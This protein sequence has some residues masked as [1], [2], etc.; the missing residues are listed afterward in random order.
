[1]YGLVAHIHEVIKYR[2]KNRCKADDMLQLMIDAASEDTR[3]IEDQDVAA[4]A[5]FFLLAGYETT[6]ITIAN[7]CCLMA[8]H[9]EE[10]EKLFEEINEVCSGPEDVTYEQVQKLKRMEAFLLETLRMFPPV[11]SLVSRVGNA[12]VQV[13]GFHIPKGTQVQASVLEVHM[14][15]KYWPDPERFNPDRFVDTNAATQPQYLPFGIGPKMCIGRRFSLIELKITFVTILR[16]FRLVRSPQLAEVP[17][18]KALNM[19]LT[20]EG[21]VPLLVETRN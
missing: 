11:I 13:G 7:A 15:P 6:A 8:I 16:S 21:G 3:I 12:D 4:N 20:P 1:M 19:S 18:R 5:F 14:N 10:Q 2:K 17:H 9:P